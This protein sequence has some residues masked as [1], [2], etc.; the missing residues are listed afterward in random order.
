MLFNQHLDLPHLSGMNDLLKGKLLTHRWKQNHEQNLT[1][2]S[3][4]VQ[5]KILDIFFTSRKFL[6]ETACT[7]LLYFYWTQERHKCLST[8]SCRHNSDLTTGQL[9]TVHS[10]TYFMCLMSCVPHA[11]QDTDQFFFL[12]IIQLVVQFI[13]L[14]K[15]WSH[16]FAK[17][18]QSTVTSAFI[19]ST[20]CKTERTY[21]ASLCGM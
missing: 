17:S 1:E 14:V 3:P 6:V 9:E 21:S 4:R 10:K 8:I 19:L 2:I 13:F 20:V 5:K 16:L 7:F 15:N 18:K 12:F 11:K